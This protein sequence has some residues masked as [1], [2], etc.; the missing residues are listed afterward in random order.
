[1]HCYKVNAYRVVCRRGD[2]RGVTVSGGA[3]DQRHGGRRLLVYC[4][5][6]TPAHVDYIYTHYHYH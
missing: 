5:V 2:V 1:M 6:L 4:T 3:E